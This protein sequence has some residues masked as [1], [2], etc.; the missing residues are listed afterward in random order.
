MAENKDYKNNT[1]KNTGDKE[2]VKEYREAQNKVQEEKVNLTKKIK[3]KLETI[4]GKNTLY[5]MVLLAFPVLFYLLITLSYSS[6][7]EILEVE[8]KDALFSFLT[9]LYGYY[10]SIVNFGWIFGGIF[11]LTGYQN[12]SMW[13]Y[14]HRDFLMET[15]ASSPDSK[16]ELPF[17]I[18]MGTLAVL[19]GISLFF[20]QVIPNA[21]F[22]HKYPAFWKEQLLDYEK[23]TK[24]YE[25]LASFEAQRGDFSIVEKAKKEADL[26]KIKK[27]ILNFAKVKYEIVLENLKIKNEKKRKY[28][29]VD[30]VNALRGIYQ[31]AII[32][33]DS[34]FANQIAAFTNEEWINE[35]STNQTVKNEME[36][37]AVLFDSSSFAKD[38][39]KIDFCFVGK[40]NKPISHRDL[41]NPKLND[42]KN[43]VLLK[44]QLFIL[45]FMIM[46]LR[47][48]PA[49]SIYRYLKKQYNIDFSKEEKLI[50]SGARKITTDYYQNKNK[51]FSDYL[52]FSLTITLPRMIEENRKRVINEYSK[53][54]NDNPRK[55][56]TLLSKQ[57][58]QNELVYD[59][60]NYKMYLEAIFSNILYELMTGVLE[61]NKNKYNGLKADLDIC[62]KIVESVFIEQVL[63]LNSEYFTIEPSKYQP[64]LILPI[65]QDLQKISI[66]NLY[67]LV[68]DY[69]KMSGVYDNSLRP[70]PLYKM[71]FNGDKSGSLRG[72]VDKNEKYFFGG[73]Q[74]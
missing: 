23:L 49:H 24:D 7:S 39:D 59:L 58:V 54:L 37:Y 67:E 38:M 28:T 66:E 33:G 71:Y 19:I 5:F 31:I 25:K 18:Q 4:S 57:A 43:V 15:F 2:T 10:I 26:K 65:L 3:I 22:E 17:I 45:L 8:E 46:F 16:E 40:G 56:I 53:F 52:P 14:E 34:Q 27:E 73:N 11:D 13:V 21:W 74:I 62:K 41:L 68:Y 6:V 12:V 69:L 32:N 50:I 63:D 55:V 51:P 42:L 70:I 47:N 61:A 36:F 20:Y 35:I 64:S 60:K 1:V 44:K 48:F 29:K 9:N 30:Y 72:V